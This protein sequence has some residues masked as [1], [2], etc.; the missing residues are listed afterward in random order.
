MPQW[1]CPLYS[2]CAI[3]RYNC[4]NSYLPSQDTG[5]SVWL[6]PGRHWHTN[7]SRVS[8]QI[9]ESVQLCLSSEHSST[10]MARH[11]VNTGES[12]CIIS[13]NYS[14]FMLCN[15]VF[16]KDRSVNKDSIAANLTL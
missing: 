5:E 8:L 16:H 13:G 14:T 4:Q 9:V 2:K 7:P 3:M 11:R 12:H 10:A 15:L 1:R 6:K